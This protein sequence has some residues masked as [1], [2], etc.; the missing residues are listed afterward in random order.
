[1]D[2]VKIVKRYL[3]QLFCKKKKFFVRIFL[4]DDIFMLNSVCIIN[5]LMGNNSL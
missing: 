4:F 5:I 3:I 2:I 1:M